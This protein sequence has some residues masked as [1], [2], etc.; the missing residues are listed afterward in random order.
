MRSNASSIDADAQP[1]A[2]WLS[3]IPLNK[4]FRLKEKKTRNSKNRSRRRKRPK[5]S[6]LKPKRR[7]SPI[8]KKNLHQRKE[9]K[10]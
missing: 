9:K 6:K 1:T 5:R 8:R 3:N 4:G 7:V 10:L 2:W